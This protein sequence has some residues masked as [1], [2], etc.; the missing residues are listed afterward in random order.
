MQCGF[1]QEFMS[2]SLSLYHTR[3]Y[4]H[5]EHMYICLR[6]TACSSITNNIYYM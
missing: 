5:K 4:I 1:T 6:K 2:T 3:R